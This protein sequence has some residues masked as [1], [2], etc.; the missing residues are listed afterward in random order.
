MFQVP[1]LAGSVC[2]HA[3]VLNWAYR[4]EDCHE[5]ALCCFDAGRDCTLTTRAVCACAVG[6]H[7][8]EDYGQGIPDRPLRDLRASRTGGR[9]GLVVT[10]SKVTSGISDRA[11]QEGWRSLRAGWPSTCQSSK[12]FSRSPRDP[13]FGYW[14][15]PNAGHSA[16]EASRDRPATAHVLDIVLRICSPH[17]DAA[18]DELASIL[19][20]RTNECS[21]TA[22]QLAFRAATCS[23]A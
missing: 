12:V 6:P 14:P 20:S 11:T 10:P 15:Q 13:S 17:A 2:P 22:S 4:H 8:A 18:S 19:D 16:N 9:H 5:A 3:A 21:E 1:G 7:A 23:H